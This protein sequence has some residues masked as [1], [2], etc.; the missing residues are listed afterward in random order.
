MASPRSKRLV[1]RP[2]MTGRSE[3]ILES[4]SEILPETS[5]K[6]LST[7]TE[8]V[9]LRNQQTMSKC[10]LSPQNFSLRTAPMRT[11]TNLLNKTKSTYSNL[12]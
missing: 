12:S 6:V 11:T 4:L 10:V 3:M 2:V 7:Q 5:A 8:S 9:K 1:L